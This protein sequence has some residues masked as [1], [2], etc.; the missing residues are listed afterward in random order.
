[1]GNSMLKVG[2]KVSPRYHM[3]NTGVILEIVLVP[4]TAEMYGGTLSKMLIAKVQMDKTG[5][6]NTF[7]V[8]ELIPAD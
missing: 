8:S 4:V 1:M 3:S 5:D 7:K 2:Q 6:V